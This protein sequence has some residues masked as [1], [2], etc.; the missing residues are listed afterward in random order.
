MQVD[1]AVIRRGSNRLSVFVAT[2]GWSRASF[3]EF[4]TDERVGNLDRGAR[5]RLSRVRR[6]AARVLAPNKRT[7]IG[8]EAILVHRG[9]EDLVSRWGIV[10]L[11][12]I[13][14]RQIDALSRAKHSA[15]PGLYIG[16]DSPQPQ[17]HIERID[18]KSR[19]EGQL[20]DPVLF[21]PYLSVPREC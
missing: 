3:V 15:L 1:W 7:P 21:L 5:E 18:A 16:R 2:S 17:S 12:A 4:V 19:P 9:C 11:S 20:A 14:L 8:S 10:P 13:C 6:G